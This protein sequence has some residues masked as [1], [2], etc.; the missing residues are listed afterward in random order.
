MPDRPDNHTVHCPTEMVWKRD[1]YR[2]RMDEDGVGLFL[3]RTAYEQAEVAEM[4]GFWAAV[5]EARESDHGCFRAPEPPATGNSW[6]QGVDYAAK[7]A[8]RVAVEAID[9]EFG[10]AADEEVPF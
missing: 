10:P 4:L 1:G 7:K 6:S 3:D 5:V 9:R 8:K 2:I